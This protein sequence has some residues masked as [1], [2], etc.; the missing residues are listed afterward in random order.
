MPTEDLA[1]V[2]AALI[3]GALLL[4]TVV[5][6]GRVARTL[7]GMHVAHTF[8]GVSLIPAVLAF[9]AIFGVGGII[10]TQLF[11]LAGWS[12]ALVGIVLG[13]AGFAIAYALY[14][15]MRRAESPRA[16]STADLVGHQGAVRV[17]IP[18]GQL[19]KV[20]VQVGGLARDVDATSATE[21]TSGTVVRAVGMAG[22]ALVVERLTPQPIV[23]PTPPTPPGAGS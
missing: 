16:L 15:T 17:T 22:A 5:L 10:G 19:G 12:A 2:L 4:V 3:G 7:D 14:G 21:I 6:D 18:A 1:F 8:R 9:V 23:M 20:S 11:N 13:V